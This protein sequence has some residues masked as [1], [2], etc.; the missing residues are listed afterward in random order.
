VRTGPVLLRPSLPG[1]PL[2]C[3]NMETRATF[4]ERQNCRSLDQSCLTSQFNFLL[5]SVPRSWIQE[6]LSHQGSGKIDL[7]CLCRVRPTVS[8]SHVFKRIDHILKRTKLAV[9]LSRLVFVDDEPTQDWKQYLAPHPGYTHC[10][11]QP[12]TFQTMTKRQQGNLESQLRQRNTCPD[13]QER[14]LPVTLSMNRVN[15]SGSELHLSLGTLNLPKTK[16]LQL[17]YPPSQQVTRVFRQSRMFLQSNL[18][19]PTPIG[20]LHQVHPQVV[21]PSSSGRGDRLPSTEAARPRIFS[22]PVLRVRV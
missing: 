21:L 4:V 20:A 11:E 2:I 14:N 19:T 9:I 18:E 8:I 17:L 10:Q 13:P 3:H 7:A 5:K 15:G 16:Q 1:L 6:H 22:N 12:E